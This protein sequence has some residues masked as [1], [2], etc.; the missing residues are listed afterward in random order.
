MSHFPVLVIGRNV[1]EQLQ[2]YH[3]Y[4]CTGINDQYVQDVDITEK[5]L[6]L[7]K[8]GKTLLEALAEYGLEERMV[9][10]E[11]EVDRQGEHKW[12]YA[13]VVDGILH[14]AVDRTNPN[15]KW[16]WWTSGGRW[17]GF[18]LCADGNRCNQ[19]Y[20]Q[21]WD[22]EGQRQAKAV[23]AG[24]YY[25]F[26]HRVAGHPIPSWRETREKH[27][28]NIEVAREEYRSN[29]AI[30]NIQK[31]RDIYPLIDLEPFRDTRESYVAAEVAKVGVPYALVK[32]GQWH[33]KGEMGW[34]G[35]S[36][37]EVTQE[38]W[39]KQVHELLASLSDDTEL[40]IIDCHI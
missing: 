16:D 30:Q 40:Y 6:E 8:N 39:N 24:D 2:P 29:P 17:T 19:T 32:D 14:K 33:Q 23:E 5:V 38:D 11:T 31:N 15:A 4:E 20:K 13:I 9:V 27:G 28:T 3:E 21:H 25:D 7:I 1:A 10:S 22:L 18:F 35:T 34:W 26:I 37:E 12:G 36:T